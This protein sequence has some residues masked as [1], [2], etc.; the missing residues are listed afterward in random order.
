MSHVLRR[1]NLFLRLTQFYTSTVSNNISISTSVFTITR[2]SSG[3]LL[4]L[5]RSN[6]RKLLL[7]LLL[8]T[9]TIPDTEK[10]DSKRNKWYANNNK[11]QKAII[12]ARYMLISRFLAVL[13]STRCAWN[14]SRQLSIVAFI[15]QGRW[16]GGERGSIRELPRH[17]P[18]HMCANVSRTG[19]ACDGVGGRGVC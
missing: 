15:A 14:P 16:H 4:G 19:I 5:P 17:L 8:P 9:T 3:S 13:Q 11:P 6:R 12:R 1:I 2:L 18:R 7:P 10:N